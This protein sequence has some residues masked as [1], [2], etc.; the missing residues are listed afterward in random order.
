MWQKEGCFCVL[1][2]I[3][4]ANTILF[5]NSA[6]T[7]DSYGEA[8]LAAGKSAEAVKSYQKAVNLAEKHKDSNLKVF[9]ANLKTAEK[10][11]V[12]RP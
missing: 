8:L 9:K 12:K 10:S 1:V 6:N 4:K 3:F 2:V 5:P 11:A 7:Y